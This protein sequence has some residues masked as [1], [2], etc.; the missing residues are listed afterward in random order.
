VTDRRVRELLQEWSDICEDILDA[1]FVE[2]FPLTLTVIIVVCMI[3]V[4]IIIWSG[5][6]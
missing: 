4:G 6:S 3:C 1:L 5:L 2:F